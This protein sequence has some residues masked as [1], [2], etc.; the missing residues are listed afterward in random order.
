MVKARVLAVDQYT[1]V[2]DP[3]HL[4]TQTF[5]KSELQDVPIYDEASSTCITDPHTLS[6]RALLFETSA[7]LVHGHAAA[8]LCIDIRS[9]ASAN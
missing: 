5:F 2:I 7:K 4:A 9:K 8:R 1:V 3:G 6:A